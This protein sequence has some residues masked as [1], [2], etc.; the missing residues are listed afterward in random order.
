MKYIIK[1][2][3]PDGSVWYHCDTTCAV[4]ELAKNAKRYAYDEFYTT[5]PS[6]QLARVRKN[7]EHRWK[8]N[9]MFGFVLGASDEY[10]NAPCW[11]GYSIEEIQT[12][13]EIIVPWLLSI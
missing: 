5:E 6:D 3:L 4:N 2:I 7:F 13:T 10:R 9:V 11:K 8:E 1:H 12:V